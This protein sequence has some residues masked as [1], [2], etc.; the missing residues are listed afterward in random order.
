MRVTDKLGVPAVRG[1]ALGVSA[2]FAVALPAV[3]EA[4]PAVLT[5]GT[6]VGPAGHRFAASS[7]GDIVFEAGPVTVTCAR[8][9]SVPTTGRL[10]QVPA[11]PGNSS[12]DG[13]VVLN[14]NPPAFESC[15][16]NAP[17]LKASI[18]TNADHG[19]WQV[20]LRN[21]APARLIIP[22]QG[23]VL[24]TSGLLKCKATA[25]PSAAAGTEAAW[26]NGTPSSLSFAGANIPVKIE[27]GFFCPTS[28]NTATITA[29]YKVTDSTDPASSI[30]VSGTPQHCPL[31][32]AAAPA[33]PGTAPSHGRGR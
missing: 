1:L 21:G 30:T 22:A 8:S 24:K 10:N 26:T 17:G 23:F 32:R 3:A 25:A 14:I 28:V 5:T 9:A 20:A 18:T 11:K 31:R 7:E 12:A 16:T 15:T 4:G 2:A 29:N 27:G 6:T 33:V 19:S 13:P